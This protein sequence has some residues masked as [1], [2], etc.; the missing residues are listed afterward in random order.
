MKQKALFYLGRAVTAAPELFLSAATLYAAQVPVQSLLLAP[1]MNPLM[2]GVLFVAG[3]AATSV[4]AYGTYLLLSA[5]SKICEEKRRIKSNPEQFP[6]ECVDRIT[7]ADKPGLECLLQS[8]ETQKEWGTLLKSHAEGKTGVID[9]ILDPAESVQKGLI[10]HTTFCTVRVSDEKVAE[11]KY[12]GVHHYHPSCLGAAS[13][14]ISH[15]DR[16]TPIDWLNLLTF[17]LDGIPEL[18]AYNK[19]YVYLPQDASKQTLVRASPRDIMEYLGKR[20]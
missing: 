9:V 1:H 17:K 7:V 3:T 4:C 15:V 11:G 20:K 14:N 6:L 10:E 18:I 8:T 5:R 2:G 13:F 16:S 12:N 19:N